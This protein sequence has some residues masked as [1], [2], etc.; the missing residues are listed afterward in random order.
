MLSMLT[1]EG[2]WSDD[3]MSWIGIKSHQGKVAQIKLDWAFSYVDGLFNDD[4][5]TNFWFE[6]KF[7]YSDLA[8][9]FNA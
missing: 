1:Y 4:V 9:F 3:Q 8:L 7:C 6:G 2:G 5:S